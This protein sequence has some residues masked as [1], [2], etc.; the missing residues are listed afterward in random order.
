M[1][2]NT[3]P[4]SPEEELNPPPPAD[5]TLNS[6]A[7]QLTVAVN[8]AYLSQQNQAAILLQNEE[9]RKALAQISSDLLALRGE[10]NQ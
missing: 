8:A 5:A 1:T 7:A 4:V 9:T 10:K 3:E 2:E 6:L